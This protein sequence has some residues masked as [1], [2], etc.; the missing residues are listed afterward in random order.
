M[1]PSGRDKPSAPLEELARKA[2][3][4]QHALTR[5]EVSLFREEAAALESQLR[6]S[7]PLGRRLW[8][9][10][11]P[12]LSDSLGPRRVA[13]QDKTRSGRRA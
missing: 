4:S 6:E 5:E 2:R 3:F 12:I 7:L 13:P 11:G 8:L 10:I 9:Q 1:L